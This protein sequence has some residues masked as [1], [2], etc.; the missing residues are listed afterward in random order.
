MVKKAANSCSSKWNYG[1]MSSL[2][3]AEQ[4]LSRVAVRDVCCSS[5]EQAVKFRIVSVTRG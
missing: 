1:H 5:P 3:K 4:G 2:F